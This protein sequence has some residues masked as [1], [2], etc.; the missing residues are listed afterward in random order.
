VPK[1]TFGAKLS[2][3]ASAAIFGTCL[4]YPLDMMKTQIQT[5]KGVVRLSGLLDTAS[6]I[7]AANGPRGLYKGTLR[8][9]SP[10][11]EV[12]CVSAKA[13]GS[14]LGWRLSG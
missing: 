6:A 12:F 10:K 2:V 4:I 13:A 8:T 9:R 1:V 5:S 11:A 7:V 14:V 3:G